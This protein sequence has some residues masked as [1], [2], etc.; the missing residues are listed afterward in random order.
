MYDPKW[1]HG[2]T[3]YGRMCRVLA[4]DGYRVSILMCINRK[5]AR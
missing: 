5:N 1:P 4:T 3:Y 2:H